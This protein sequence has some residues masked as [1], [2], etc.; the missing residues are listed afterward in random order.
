MGSRQ[1]YVSSWGDDV[2]DGERR[3]Y[4]AGRGEEG[5]KRRTIRA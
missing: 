2:G 5:L 1:A 4:D 3:R